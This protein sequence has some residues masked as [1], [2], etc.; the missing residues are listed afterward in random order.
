MDDDPRKAWTVQKSVETGYGG[1]PLPGRNP[2]GGGGG[3]RPYTKGHAQGQ[4]NQLSDAWAVAGAR[5]T[6]G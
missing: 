4:V 6:P 5:E 3:G 2:G 1:E